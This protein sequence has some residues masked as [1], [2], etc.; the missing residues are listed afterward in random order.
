MLLRLR[1]AGYP[2]GAGGTTTVPE[3]SLRRHE[4]DG[5]GWILRPF[6][7]GQSMLRRLKADG[8]MLAG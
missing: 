5:G 2:L 4:A 3:S 7:A 8:G 6:L 1:R